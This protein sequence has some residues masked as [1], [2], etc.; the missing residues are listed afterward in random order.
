MTRGLEITTTQKAENKNALP[1]DPEQIL[2]Y[3]EED[4]IQISWVPTE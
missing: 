2:Q 4:G 3:P 1:L